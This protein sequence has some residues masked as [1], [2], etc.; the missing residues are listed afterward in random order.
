MPLSVITLMINQ[1]LCEVWN[2]SEF[3][4]V[5]VFQTLVLKLQTANLLAFSPHI[6]QYNPIFPNSTFF[7]NYHSFMLSFGGSSL[8]L[9]GEKAVSIAMIS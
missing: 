4:G 1:T 6:L 5:H 2:A 7:L 9:M 8:I 3:T